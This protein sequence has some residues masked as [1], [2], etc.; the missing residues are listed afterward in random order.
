MDKNCVDK[1][2]LYNSY[3]F[4]KN[5]LGTLDVLLLKQFEISSKLKKW[6]YINFDFDTFVEVCSSIT[7]FKNFEKFNNQEELVGV[8]YSGGTASTLLILRALEEGKYVLP[9][10]NIYNIS[11][12]QLFWV[13]NL[14]L[15]NDK[16]HRVLKPVRL[17]EGAFT[18]GM[19]LN[20]KNGNIKQ[21][22]NGISPYYLS[23]NYYSSLKE[24]Q[25][26]NIPGRSTADHL[27]EVDKIG[28]LVSKMVNIKPPKITRPLFEKTKEEVQ[29]ELDS[30]GMDLLDYTCSY[31][32][33]KCLSSKKHKWLLF[34]LT[35]CGN[36]KSCRV[37]SAANIPLKKVLLGLSYGRK[38]V[39]EDILRK[40]GVII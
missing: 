16:Y 21:L 29:S 31:P 23:S 15:I 13:K 3:S 22:I 38:S 30:Y 20:W 18:Y 39:S 34:I 26:G 19:S 14:E 40:E 36:C 1:M 2:N 6:E 10:Y 37:N 32:N 11:V 12:E 28:K 7:S 33:I 24:I 5:D 8:M 4:K 17:T 35:E 25:F 27:E 9:I